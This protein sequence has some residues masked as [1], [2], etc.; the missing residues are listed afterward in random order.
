MSDDQKP[1]LPYTQRTGIEPVPPQLGLSEI[2][3]ELRRLLDYYM[4]QEINR[5]LRSTYAG[6]WFRE[7]FAR[8]LQD[9]HVKFF[10]K[11]IATYR[12][13]ARYASKDLE[14]A[15][16][17]LPIGTLF[18]LIEKV[19]RHPNCSDQLKHDW[20][21]AFIEA[22]AAYRITDEGIIVA[23][24]TD[25]QAEAYLRAIHEA[26]ARDAGP[27]RAHLLA[28]G[29]ALRDGDWASS[30]R[31][32]ISAVE[33]MARRLAPGATKLS[34][35]LTEIEKRGHLHRGLKQA[36]ATLYGYSSDEPGVRHPLVFDDEAKVDEA[37]AV[38][39]LGACAA[40]VSYLLA[41]EE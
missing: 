38:F 5:N 27:V 19:V 35:A 32:S 33:S 37:D 2:S 40:F 16:D 4:I 28:A 41:H 20:S 1:Y 22:R 12:S 9:L 10:G 39:M 15:V 23:I 8:L 21:Q 11:P 26:K 34:D 17:R 24:G 25:E 6:A 14:S 31:E 13:E 30:V 36:F 7:E 3:K 18:N 29:A